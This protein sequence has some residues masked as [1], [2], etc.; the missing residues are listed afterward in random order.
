VW[1]LFSYFDP[2]HDK[3]VPCALVTWFIH[4][5]DNPECDEVTRMWKLQREQSIDGQ[6][7]IQVIHLNTILHG[8]HLLPCYGKGFLPVELK[9]TNALDTWISYFVN[10]FIDNHAHELLT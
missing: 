8:A 3:D 7:P 5:D 4:Q 2:Y 1:L 6:H 9:Y 10:Q